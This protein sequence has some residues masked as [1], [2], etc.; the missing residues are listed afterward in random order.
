MDSH[1]PADAPHTLL[2]VFDATVTVDLARMVE[3]LPAS[4]N[5]QIETA[6]LPVIDAVRQARLSH[7]GRPLGVYCPDE[8]GTLSAI[9]AGADD[10]QTLGDQLP[11]QRSVLAFL[12]RVHLRARLRRHQE[13]LQASAVQS[14]KLAALGTV[15]AG[16]AHEVNNPLAALMLTVEAI[17]VQLGPLRGEL[18]GN[19]S[20]VS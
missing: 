13:R 4:R 18:S 7:G 16:V 6:E 20:F 10:A 8:S 9:E 15:V 2:L 12:D 1:F 17:R 14:E 11:S 19:R 3:G 5:C